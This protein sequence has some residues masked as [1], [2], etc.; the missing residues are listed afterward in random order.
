MQLS[1]GQPPIGSLMPIAPSNLHRKS[2]I[3]SRTLPTLKFLSGNDWRKATPPRHPPCLSLW[4][5]WPSAART[6]RVN[7]EDTV[8]R[9]Y[10]TNAA[11]PSQ[12]RLRRAS[13]P[14]GRAKVAFSIAAERTELFPIKTR[15]VPPYVI[16]T[17]ASAEWRNPPRGR[18]VPTQGKI[19]NLRR[20]LDS[21]RFARN[22]MPGVVLF[23]PQVIHPTWRAAGCRPYDTF[24]SYYRLFDA[25]I[26]VLRFEKCENVVH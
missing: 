11:R 1:G 3:D 14:R 4:E 21:L 24:V 6:E 2:A 5:R 23:F 8:G 16:P 20:F 15:H 12:S 26:I 7:V 25:S 10:L 13:S 17:R 18:K 22:D 9:D 19:C